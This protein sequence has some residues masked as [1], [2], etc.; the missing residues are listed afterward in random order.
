MKEGGSYAVTPTQLRPSARPIHY[1]T[2]DGVLAIR[3]AGA[4]EF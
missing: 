4:T 3:H 1:C 2:T